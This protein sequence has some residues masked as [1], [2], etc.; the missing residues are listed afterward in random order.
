MPALG[1]DPKLSHLQEIYNFFQPVGYPGPS[2]QAAYDSLNTHIV[3][4]MFTNYCTNKKSAND[5]VAEAAKR[6]DD[7]LK[8]FPV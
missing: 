8:K 2:S 7:S 4:D 1:S 3:T 5:A 6:L